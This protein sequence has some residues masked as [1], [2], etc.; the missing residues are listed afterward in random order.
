MDH[1]DQELQQCSR[2][3]D[4]ADTQVQSSLPG[5][6]AAAGQ[7]E[8]MKELGAFIAPHTSKEQLKVVPFPFHTHIGVPLPTS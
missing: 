8:E 3:M 5:D 4:Q 6:A 7:S 2:L 1:S